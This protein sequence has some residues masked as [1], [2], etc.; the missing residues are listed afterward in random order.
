LSVQSLKGTKKLPAVSNTS[1]THVNYVF[2]SDIQEHITIDFMLFK[3][4][5]KVA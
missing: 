5:R 2:A 4:W 1:H 3:E